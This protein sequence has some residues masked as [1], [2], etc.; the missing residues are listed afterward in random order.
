MG[1]PEKE[2]KAIL[3]ARGLEEEQKSGLQAGWGCKDVYT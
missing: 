3:K 1:P 2:S